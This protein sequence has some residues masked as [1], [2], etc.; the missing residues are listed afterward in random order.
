MMGRRRTRWLAPL[1]VLCAIRAALAQYDPPA[2]Y[3]NTA[4]GTGATLK[5]QLNDIIDGHT[6]FSYDALR[7]ILQVTDA[8]PNAAGRM[9]LVYDR[10]SL[11][12][13]AINP[14]GSIPGWDSG[15]SWN[16]EHVW[17]QAV[18]VDT[19]SPPDGSDLHH[20][21]PSD[22]G[23]NS[24]RGNLDFGGAYG[25]RPSGQMFGTLS[26]GGQTY[27]Y[28]GDADAGMIAREVFYMAVRYDGADSG[29]VDLELAAG[30]PSGNNMGNLT[31]MI[32]W[33]YAR[34][35]DN[36][37]RRRNQII[38]DSYQRNRNPF[39][40]NPAWAWSI[41]VDQA[42]DSQV[43]IAGATVNSSG[44]SA[45]T[46]DLGRIYVGGTVPSPTA[47]TIN[48]AGD[49]GTYFSVTTS[50]AATSSLSG[51]FNPMR[52]GGTDSRA[53]SVG[54][55][56][57]STTAGLKTGTV[58]IDNLD[59]TT[60]GGFGRGANDANDTITVNLNVLNHPVASFSSN[61][62]IRTQTIDF[63]TVPLGVTTQQSVYS[64]FNL[65]ASGGGPAFPANLDLDSLTGSGDTD[66]LSAGATLF[67]NLAAGGAS[68][69]QALLIPTRLGSL[70]ASYTLNLSGENLPGAQN[71]TLTLELLANVVPASL[72][73]DYNDNGSVDAA[74]YTVWREAN[75]T[76][77]VLPNDS[78][79]DGVTQADYE[80]WA[81]NLGATAAT[82]AG[83]A[84]PEPAAMAMALFALISATRRKYAHHR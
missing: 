64:L 24:D 5:A 52:T 82:A 63:G 48:K 67:S 8:D 50:G 37:E 71:Q 30:A 56:T 62:N 22:N 60:A 65:A 84:I 57:T 47:L 49:D 59:I 54:L 1:L 28:P 29:T 45:R 16:R 23:I 76:S 26:E 69:F 72:W 27:W 68:A 83:L 36:F 33:N 66:V 58:T 77:T 18:G 39:I 38:Y 7:T 12:V 81:N 2:T 74:D 10:T 46:V 40:D 34:A 11:N 15:V 44:A 3:Y 78:T 42:N 41:F 14:G 75:G 61:S 31:R 35:P 25:S 32:E 80:V 13:A 51:A 17:P 55:A 21:R 43:S 20:L 79:P 70:F 73:G 6:T 19:T 4:T 53:I 9:I